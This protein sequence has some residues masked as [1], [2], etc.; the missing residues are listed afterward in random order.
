MDYAN[1]LLIQENL[2][3]DEIAIQSGY[4]STNTFRRAFRRVNGLSPTE[5]IKAFRKDIEDTK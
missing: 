4:N 2:S 5:Y 1:S 3:I